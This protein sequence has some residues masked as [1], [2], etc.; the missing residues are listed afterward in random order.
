MP[1]KYRYSKRAVRKIRTFYKNVALKYRYAYSYED[2]ERNVRDAIFYIYAIEAESLLSSDGKAITW[3]TPT[4]G[5]TL[6]PLR[7]IQSPLWML[8]TPKTCM[9]DRPFSSQP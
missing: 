9:T 3:P 5:I 8:V 7:A 4:N 1:Y 6:T 2:M